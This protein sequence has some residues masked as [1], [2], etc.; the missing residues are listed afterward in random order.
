MK[1]DSKEIETEV[2]VEGKALHVERLGK[3]W[4]TFLPKTLSYKFIF[5]IVYGLSRQVMFLWIKSV[6][7]SCVPGW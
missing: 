1:A 3:S 4:G 5:C 6:Y 2:F 7:W